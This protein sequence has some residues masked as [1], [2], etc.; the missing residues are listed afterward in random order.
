MSIKFIQ[1]YCWTQGQHKKMITFPTYQ[2]L[3]ISK[4]D[5]KNKNLIHNGTIKYE[6]PSD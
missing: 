4:C 2:S 6:V 5:R 3:P 1:Q